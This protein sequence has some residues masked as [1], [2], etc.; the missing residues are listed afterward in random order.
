VAIKARLNLK[1]ILTEPEPISVDVPTT[2]T[3][4]GT[5]RVQDVALALPGLYEV[6][7]QGGITTLQQAGTDTTQQAR[8]FGDYHVEIVRGRVIQVGGDGPHAGRSY[9][10]GPIDNFGSHVEAPLE[11]V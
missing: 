5:K 9:R 6:H 2:V 8:L 10:L 4:D 7:D 11:D 3:V 1:A